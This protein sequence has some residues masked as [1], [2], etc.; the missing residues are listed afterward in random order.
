MLNEP[1]EPAGARFLSVAEVAAA[2]GCHERTVYNWHDKGLL[3]CVHLGGR[4]LTPAS[5]LEDL[6]RQARLDAE[7]RRAVVAE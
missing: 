1:N 3:P 5:A 4:R 7:Q 2:L 6:E